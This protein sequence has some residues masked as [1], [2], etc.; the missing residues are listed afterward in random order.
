[1]GRDHFGIVEL[2]GNCPV[3]IDK[4]DTGVNLCHSV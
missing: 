4:F 1:M 2:D 3:R